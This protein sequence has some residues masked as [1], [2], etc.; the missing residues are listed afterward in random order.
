[1]P[2]LENWGGRLK[3]LDCCAHCKSSATLCCIKHNQNTITYYTLYCT[4]VFIIVLHLFCNEL[5]TVLLQVK[6]AMS[7][8]Q[9][10]AVSVPNPI[11]ATSLPPSS[12]SSPSVD[13]SGKPPSSEA[14]SQQQQQSQQS[15]EQ[16]SKTQQLSSAA[17]KQV[18]LTTMKHPPGIDPMAIMKERE[19]R[20]C[21]ERVSW[22]CVCVPV[23]V[24]MCASVCCM[25]VCVCMCASVYCMCVCAVCLCVVV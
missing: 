4:C 18:K 5:C 3:I 23:C 16:Q 11:S 20:Y 1:M 6:Q 14:S 12:S 2:N 9:S 25:C 10:V 22:V 24:C 21:I 17:L 15:S 8:S 7:S 13:S 19:T